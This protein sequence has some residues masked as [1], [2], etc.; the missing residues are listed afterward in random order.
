MP[1][2]AY[3]AQS[4]SARPPMPRLASHCLYLWPKTTVLEVPSGIAVTRF[5]CLPGALAE[6]LPAEAGLGSNTISV[7]LARLRAKLTGTGVR[8]ETVRSIG[9]RIVAA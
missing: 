9:Y 3:Q 8:I 5:K 7:H 4:V 1:S 6:V 2:R